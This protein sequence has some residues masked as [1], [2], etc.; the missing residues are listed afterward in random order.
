M[1]GFIINPVERSVEEVDRP[2]E[3]LDEL[4]TAV[5]GYIELAGIIEDQ[6]GNPNVV[7]C[8]EEG[9]LK[10]PTHFTLIE[11]FGNP[12]A[13][14]VLILGSDMES[15][16]SSDCTLSLMSVCDKVTYMT[17]TEVRTLVQQG[18]YR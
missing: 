17:A 7:Y 10:G 18:V 9:L 2:F 11:G 8:D 5:G 15:G 6:E 3:N 1:K 12:I 4:Q 14:S 16:E 13:G